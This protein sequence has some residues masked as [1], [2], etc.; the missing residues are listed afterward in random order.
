MP[1]CRFFAIYL[2][3]WVFSEL[4]GSVLWGSVINFGNLSAFVASNI[5]SVPSFYFWYSH[6]LY[7]TPFVIVLTVL[8]CFVAFFS[9]LFLFAFESG[10]FLLRYLQAQWFFSLAVSNLLMSPARFIFITVFLISSILFWFFLRVSTSLLTKLIYSYMFTFS[11]RALNIL[12]VILNS[13][14]DNYNMC[15]MSESGFD[16]FLSRL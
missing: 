15:V 9:F 11:I 10:K 8:E 6:Y 4:P 16:A 2:S 5:S 12:I 14:S 13:R 7:V 1:R 3:F